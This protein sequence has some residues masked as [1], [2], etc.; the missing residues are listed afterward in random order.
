MPIWK[1]CIS[2][3]QSHP[4]EAMTIFYLIILQNLAVLCLFL[5]VVILMDL[6]AERSVSLLT[7]TSRCPL[8]PYA[9]D[10]GFTVSPA[11]LDPAMALALSLLVTALY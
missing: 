10:V 2:S 11:G 5:T 7:I 1:I 3:P 9:R 8:K 4:S 6:K